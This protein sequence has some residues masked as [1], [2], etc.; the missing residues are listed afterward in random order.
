MRGGEREKRSEGGKGT[1]G[2][3]NEREGQVSVDR[4]FEEKMQEESPRE[5]SNGTGTMREGE[6]DLG[7]RWRR[8]GRS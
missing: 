3:G 6:T 7:A 4:V 8:I 1:E 5:N 2:E